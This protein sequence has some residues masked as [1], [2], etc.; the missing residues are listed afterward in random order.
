MTHRK[1]HR[2]APIASLLAL[3]SSNVLYAFDEG[4]HFNTIEQPTTQTATVTVFQS[5][6]CKPCAIVHG[7]LVKAANKLG[8]EFQEVPVPFG[9]LYDD[10][11]RGY[12]LAHREGKAQQYIGKLIHRVHHKRNA[13]PKCVQDIISVLQECD[14]NGEV[15][16]CDCKELEDGVYKMNMLVKQYRIRATPTIIVNGNKEVILHNL[17]S[18]GELNELIEYLIELDS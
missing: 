1:N 15:L 8:A 2:L 17:K 4:T 3:I 5:I 16:L 7:P 12:V 11:Q 13:A 10:I 9:A 14:V 18:L 6:Y